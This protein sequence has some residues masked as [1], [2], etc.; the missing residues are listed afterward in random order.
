MHLYKDT[1]MNW[2]LGDI[3]EGI[4]QTVPPETDALIHG[5]RTL[6]WGE[7]ARRSNNLV[8]QLQDMGLQP[9]DKIAFYLRNQPAYMEALVVCFKGGFVHTN[10]NY[11][12]TDDELLYILDNSDAAA[13][14]FDDEFSS[15]VADIRDRADKVNHW[16]NVSD[17]ASREIA[18]EH[19]YEAL[20]LRGDGAAP[21]V[22]RSPDDL[23]FIYTGGTTGMPKGVMWRQEDFF[24]GMGGGA[25]PALGLPAPQ[26]LAQHLAA[27][28]PIAGSSRQ[29]IGSPLMHGMGMITGV[30]TLLLGGTVITLTQANFDANEAWEVVTKTRATGM[31]IVGDVFARP[32][33]RALQ[34][35][36]GQ[37]ELS[38]M[39]GIVSSGVM[40]SKEVKQGLLEYLPQAAL[41]DGFSSSEAFGLAASVTTIDGETEAATFSVG[42]DC[43]VFS[44]DFR[45][46]QPGSEEP[47]LIARSG[48]IPQ[49]YY[50]D[51]E[52]S[53]KTFPVI[54][55]VRYTMPGD[56][57]TVAVDGTLTLLGR[58]SVCINTGGEKVY[59]EEVEETLKT[60]NS[61]EDALVV[62]LP[63]E[64]WGQRIVGVVQLSIRAELDQLA[65]QQHVRQSLAGYKVP[66]EIFAIDD[67]GRGPN[68][69]ADYAAIT[70]YAE[71]RSA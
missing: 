70:R 24:Y 35:N 31:S 33:L 48:P 45:E 60:H 58:G 18:G 57:C 5:E 46:I 20:A 8:T 21:N 53:A 64:R 1:E 37:Y 62:G 13:V 49:G 61:V 3:L 55:G 42:P 50:K 28:K 67:L 19:N 14:I 2:N 16:I 15:R 47:G 54:D 22:K 23:I 65:L 39:L 59:P 12:Y 34:D 68:G 69:K 63:D 71:S 17:D 27:I 32:L 4:E 30:F 52:K 36:Q 25:V 29:L 66:K 6:S 38:S 7:L 10:I 43:K 26:D 51:P 44:E 11:R 9:D 56:W 40:W 41:T